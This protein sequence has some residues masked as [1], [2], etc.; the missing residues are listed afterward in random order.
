[1]RLK[2]LVLCTTS[3]G[4]MAFAAAPALAQDA[5]PATPQSTTP[6]AADAPQTDAAD[7]GTDIVITGLRNSLASAQG[8]KRR[9]PQIVDAIVAEDI[10]KL[11]DL[12]TAQTAARIP[13]VQVYRQGGE[14]QN[15]LVRGLPFFTTTYNGREIFTAET[16][17]VALQDFPSSN[18]AAL[19]VYKSATADLVSP[20]L[21]GIVN[22]RSRKPFD[23]QNGQFSGSVWGVYTR[24]GRTTKPNFNVL[25]TKRWAVGEGEF[26]ILVQAAYQDMRYLDAEVSNT[27]FVADPV[28]NGQRIRLP[29]IQRL[30]Y[31]SGN[32]GRPAGNVQLQWRLNPTIEFYAEGLY[33]GFR[34]E[35]DD[36]LLESP[37]YGG[38]SYTNLQF[39]SG[40]NLVRSGTVTNPGGNLFSFQ[41]GTKNQTDTFQ[42][43]GGTHITSGDF[44]LTID[45]ARTLST[46]RGDTESVDRIFNGPRTVT[47]DLDQPQFTI[48]GPN[49]T[50]P[51]GQNFQGLYEENQRS[52]G[53][54]WQA[55]A[56]AQYD[57]QNSVLRNIQVGA[58]FES[59]NARR[60]F[61]N[62]YA[63]LLGS[64]IPATA[65]PLTFDVF[66]GVDFQPT[67][68][69]TTP[70]Y[71]SIQSNIVALRQF[72]ATQCAAGGAV[73][74]P[75]PLGRDCQSYLYTNGGP[76][77]ATPI[78]FA[79]ERRF[80]GYGQLA[81]GFGDT[82]NGLIGL[83]VQNARLNLPNARVGAGTVNISR[84][85][86]DWL[87][88]ASLTFHAT[89][90]I[91]FR[92]AASKTVTRPEFSQ[93]GP[94][95]FNAPPGGNLV[96]TQNSAYTANGGNPFL[97]PFTSWNY[98]ASLEYYF[99]RAGFVSA[100]YFHRTLDK[101]IQ[102][103]T[104]TFIDPTLGVIRVS[105]PINTGKGHIDGIEVQ[106][107]TFF[108]A[109]WLP[110]W[111]KAFGIQ[112]NVTYIDAKV[113]DNNGAGGLSY[114]PITDQL[115]GVSKWN[116]N[117]TGL[118]ESGPVSA[119]LSY[120]GRSS[121]AA[122]RQFRGDDLY[123]E[124]ARP[125]DRLDLSAQ[126]RLMDAATIFFD[127]TNITRTPFR[128]DLSSARAGAPR[129]DFVRYLRYDESTVSVGLRFKLGK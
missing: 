120:N 7:E 1:M 90:Q 21:A 81:F 42:F 2:T 78:Y 85:N 35:I 37:L 53:R 46:F 40:T 92:L 125:A 9:A 123:T 117:I 44:K 19:E 118:F 73:A 111:A 102:N 30:F 116:Y 28:V 14:A 124:T 49:F 72:V 60:N 69:F 54:D 4:V 36:R 82:V 10:G 65:L 79:K 45:V 11:P 91:Q 23:F 112:A 66:R 110:R 33:Q 5:P 43:A 114:Y 32:R 89:P 25:A 68:S 109:S 61:E 101:F 128:Q 113:Q 8:L 100:A 16:R 63:F 38:A 94:V 41:G 129:A 3:L 75:P 56:D 47:F 57:F 70:T 6:A 77:T 99:S 76:V 104:A 13:G 39:R 59:R 50:T 95:V 108:D 86:T 105:G 83:R 106:G 15:V 115:N 27:D 121:F 126:F 71:D 84:E 96:G 20:G 107:Q 31:R 17:V 122:T 67:N 55:R 51:A 58:R 26:G 119:R 88:S 48:T 93:L 64:N 74:A 103:T 12:N 18:I 97:Q 29:D 52:A 62:R 24:Q 34:N 80:E 98:D 22:V 87:P 127:W